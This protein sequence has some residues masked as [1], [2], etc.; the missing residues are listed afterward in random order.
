MSEQ[1]PKPE[2][3]LSRLSSETDGGDSPQANSEEGLFSEY[4]S[5]LGPLEK[6]LQALE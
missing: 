3:I 1:I 5:D 6:R 4:A 2:E